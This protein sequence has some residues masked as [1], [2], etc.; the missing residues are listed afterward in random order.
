MK[1]IAN[2][3]KKTSATLVFKSGLANHSFLIKKTVCVANTYQIL[4]TS[5]NLVKTYKLNIVYYNIYNMSNFNFY[6]FYKFL[7]GFFEFL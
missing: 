3:V 2:L 1:K 7:F 5:F 4:L 6:S